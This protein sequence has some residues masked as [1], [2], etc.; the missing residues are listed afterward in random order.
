MMS[1]IIRPN[2]VLDWSPAVRGELDRAFRSAIGTNGRSNDAYLAAPASVW[3]TEDYIYAELDLPGF[4]VED[5]EITLE[6]GMLKISGER[7]FRNN[8]GELHVNERSFGHF[9]R[10]FR[11]SDVID[12][13]SV[14]AEY[15]NGVLC[16][17][18]KKRA[19]ARPM[20]IQ[21][22]SGSSGE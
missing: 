7:S 2:A 10:S 17:T 21:I 22:K 8:R 20:R 12:H 3:E 19:E 6:K 18:L 1:T 14:D 11:I 16:L 15:N 5:L 4:T 9:E 13:E